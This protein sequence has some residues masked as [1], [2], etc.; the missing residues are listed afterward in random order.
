MSEFKLELERAFEVAS[1][2]DEFES[3]LVSPDCNDIFV[4]S[5]L[6]VFFVGGDSSELEALEPFHLRFFSEASVGDRLV[7]MNAIIE[8]LLEYRDFPVGPLLPFLAYE[9]TDHVLHDVTATLLSLTPTDENEGVTSGSFIALGALEARQGDGQSIE[10]GVIGAAILYMGDMRFLGAAHNAWAA[11]D[12][13]GRKQMLSYGSQHVTCHMQIQFLLERLE[14]ARE[15]GEFGRLAEVLARLAK[16]SSKILDQELLPPRMKLA[17]QHQGKDARD[18]MRGIAISRKTLETWT[19]AEYG[20][21]ILPRLNSLHE[22]ETKDGVP[23]VMP[24]VIN[25]WGAAGILP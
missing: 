1:D 21:L 11:L 23:R 24:M 15:P 5:I 19:T 8:F 6:H 20:A 4:R 16:E 3:L 18:G 12:V 14:Q 9:C 7:V 17:P 2:Q 25:H 22:N 10:A 13:A